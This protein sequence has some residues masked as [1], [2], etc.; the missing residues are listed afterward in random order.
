MEVLVQAIHNQ[1][2]GAFKENL[3]LYLVWKL[4]D[5]HL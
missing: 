4:G 5:I 1:M 3:N 2:M